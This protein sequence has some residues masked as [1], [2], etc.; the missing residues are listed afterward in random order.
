MLRPILLNLQT[1]NWYMGADPELTGTL[2]KKSFPYAFIQM[3]LYTNF[4]NYCKEN[5]EKK[6]T[7]PGI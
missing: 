4:Y 3:I 7:K 1:V 2:T 6:P 5:R